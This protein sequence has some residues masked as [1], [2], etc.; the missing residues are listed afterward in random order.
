MHT[1][2]V[3]ARSPGMLVLVLVL[4]E[5]HIRV[6]VIGFELRVYVNPCCSPILIVQTLDLWTKPA[7][8]W[9]TTRDGQWS[10]SMFPL[11][12]F[13]VRGKI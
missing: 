7:V 10:R 12:F 6:V 8:S 11:I 4:V 3:L 5:G 13:S 9:V 2:P 1:V